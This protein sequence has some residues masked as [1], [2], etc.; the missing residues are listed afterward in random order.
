MDDLKR[1]I[2][3]D[4]NDQFVGKYVHEDKVI[5]ALWDHPIYQEMNPGWHHDGNE[6]P[7]WFCS[8]ETYFENDAENEGVVKQIVIN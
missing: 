2:E 1:Q 7:L 4:F 5:Q 3:Q 6:F 8:E